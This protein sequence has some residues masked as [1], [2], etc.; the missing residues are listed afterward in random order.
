MEVIGWIVTVM[1]AAS[2]AGAMMKLV[3]RLEGGE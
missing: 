2:L 1:G 3:D